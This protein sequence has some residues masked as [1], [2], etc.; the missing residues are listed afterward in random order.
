MYEECGGGRWRR[1]LGT[2]V[3]VTPRSLGGQRGGRNVSMGS[4]LGT[5][6]TAVPLATPLGQEE[7][8]L[9]QQRSRMSTHASGLLAAASSAV[10]RWQPTP[11]VCDFPRGTGFEDRAGRTFPQLEGN[12]GKPVS[13]PVAANS[14]SEHSCRDSVANRALAM[15]RLAADSRCEC[16]F[17]ASVATCRC[18]D[19]RLDPLPADMLRLVLSPDGSLSGKPI[20]SAIRCHGSSLDIKSMPFRKTQGGETATIHGGLGRGDAPSLC[21]DVGTCSLPGRWA[22]FGGA[23]EIGF[24]VRETRDAA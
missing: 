12:N 21:V 18:P 17:Q 15:V 2:R 7:W 13:R 16:S 19:S 10:P 22:S 8:Q 3:S 23:R 6:H 5:S 11:D 1:G 14:R 24:G 20:I 9:W 4:G